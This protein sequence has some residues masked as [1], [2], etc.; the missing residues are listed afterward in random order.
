[1]NI[2]EI[3][4]DMGRR[5]GMFLHFGEENGWVE[6]WR[7]FI[8]KRLKF[9][10]QNFFPHFFL[11]RNFESRVSRAFYFPLLCVVNYSTSAIITALILFNVFN[12]AF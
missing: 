7:E 9:S 3:P 12:L 11:P 10:F 5:R 4:V 1:M 2:I 6:K 8:S